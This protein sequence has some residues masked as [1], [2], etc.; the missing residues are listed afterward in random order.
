MLN[1]AEAYENT[2]MMIRSL[3][4]YGFSARAGPLVLTKMGTERNRHKVKAQAT[5]HG[6]RAADC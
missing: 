3:R 4:G 1:Q 6:S 5:A 2:R